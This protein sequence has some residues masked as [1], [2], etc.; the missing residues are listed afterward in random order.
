[1]NQEHLNRQLLFLTQLMA[2]TMKPNYKNIFKK[3]KNK[4]KKKIKNL[5]IFYV[6]F[7][8]FVKVSCDKSSF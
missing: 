1:V 2:L 6:F 4:N 3:Y 7:K 5:L 8:S